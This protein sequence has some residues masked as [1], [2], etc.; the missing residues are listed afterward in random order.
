MF[1]EKR[2]LQIG[3]EVFWND[4]G[5]AECSGVY[6][7]Q[8]ILTNTGRIETND[9]ILILTDGHGSCNEVSVIEIGTRCSN[10]A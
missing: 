4:P 5:N 1:D 10:V 7:I 9:D 2:L 6:H 3:D 8:D